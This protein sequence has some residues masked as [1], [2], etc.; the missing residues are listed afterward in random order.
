MLWVNLVLLVFCEGVAWDLIAWNLL[1]QCLLGIHLK[2]PPR[3]VDVHNSLL[4]AIL[5][6]HHDGFSPF[7][8]QPRVVHLQLLQVMN[9]PQMARRFAAVCGL[10]RGNILPRQVFIGHG[11]CLQV[12]AALGVF[13]PRALALG[14]GDGGGVRVPRRLVHRRRLVQVRARL[15]RLVHALQDLGPLLEI[16]AA[17]GGVLLV[18]LHVHHVQR[19]HRL[20][21]RVFAVNG[22]LQVNNALRQ[23]FGR[24]FVEKR[25]AHPVHG[26]AEGWVNSDCSLEVRHGLVPG[27]VPPLQDPI[28]H[29]N[30]GAV[31]ADVQ[32]AHKQLLLRLPVAVARHGAVA[33]S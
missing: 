31:R 30:L 32:R 8:L 1:T 3:D 10:V 22:L 24:A 9:Q 4:L 20:H 25:G 15:L 16:P 14:Q 5:A 19:R 17:L 27:L 18:E 11:F 29:L 23:G 12:D 2:Q 6:L 21:A 13:V 26:V 28:V 33:V 7:R